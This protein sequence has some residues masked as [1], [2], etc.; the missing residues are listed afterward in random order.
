MAVVRHELADDKSGRNLPCRVIFVFSTAD[1]KVARKNREKSVAK[2]RTGLEQIER[3]V[4]QGRRNTDPTSIARRVGKLFGDRQAADY[5]RYEM[6]PLSKKEREQLP[7]PGR[8]SRR[9]EYR[10]QFT[11]DAKAAERDAAY[12][13]YSA[14][15]TAAWSWRNSEGRRRG[16][17]GFP[18]RRPAR[19]ASHTRCRG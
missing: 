6:I 12:D 8:G 18:R 3:S 14:L 16:S 7:R 19:P 13:G 17:N 2:L 5:F 10:I 15:V 9:P 1:Q 11:Y 4:E